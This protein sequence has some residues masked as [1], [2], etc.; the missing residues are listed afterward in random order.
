MMEFIEEKIDLIVFLVFYLLIIL[1]LLGILSVPLL[2]IL[3]FGLVYFMFMIIYFTINYWRLKKSKDNIVDKVDCLEEKYLIS[4][5]IKEPKNMESQGYYYALKKACKAMNDKITLLENE[6]KDYQEYIESFAH[7][8]KTP[9]AVLSLY[10]DNKRDLELK[11]EVKRINNFIEQI[12]FY[13]RSESP[14]KDYFV[15]KLSLED[16]IHTVIL[17]YKEVLLKLQIAVDI[18]DLTK[19]VFTDEKWLVF[20][21]GQIIQNSIKYRNKNNNLIEIYGIE[22]KNMVTLV[23]KDKGIGIESSD[24]PRVFEKGFT[25]NNRKKAYA[26]GMG[27][28]LCKKLCDKLNLEIKI[29]SKVEKY[30]QVEINLPISNYNLQNN[31]R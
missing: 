10:A 5:I 26:T 2:V 25:G 21:V 27:L 15:K 24:L 6:Q 9:I 30:T 17:D 4:E 20:I 14:E 7:E 19:N 29:D 23:I 18:H 1:L 13:A 12:L 16:V 22:K 31:S 11:E 3:I 8:I 28:Y